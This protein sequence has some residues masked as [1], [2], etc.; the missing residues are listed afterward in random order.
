MTASAQEYG[1]YQMRDVWNANYLNPGFFPRQQFVLSLPSVHT[2]VNAVGINRARLFTFNEAEQTNYLNLDGVL[3][4]INRDLRLRNQTQVDAL[5]FGFRAGKAFVSLSTQ[6]MADW[7]M[8]LPETL[9]RTLWEGTEPYLGDPIDLGPDLDGILYQKVS[10]GMGYMVTPRLSVGM[11]VNRL[12]GLASF[13]TERSGLTILQSKDIYQTTVNLDYRVNYYGAGQYKPIDLTVQGFENFEDAISEEDIEFSSAENFRDVNQQNNGW[14]FDFGGEYFYD[15]RLTFSAALLNVGGIMWKNGTQQVKVSGETFLDGVD[16]VALEDEEDYEFIPGID[17]IGTFEATSNVAYRQNLGPRAYLGANYLVKP[18]LE[19][20]GLFYNDF[21]RDRGMTAFSLSSRLMLGR[22]FSLGALYTIQSGTFNNLG[23]NA[24]LK[25]GPFQLY[26]V[27]DNLSPLINPERID[28]ANFRFGMNLTFGRKKSEEILGYSRLGLEYPK[29][30]EGIASAPKPPRSRKKKKKKDKK[31]KE[32][33]PEEAVAEAPAEAEFAPAAAEAASFYKL[34][35]DL[36]DE[37]SRGPVNPVYVDVY[38]LDTDGYTTLLRT[39]RFPKGEVDM[40]LEASSD[41]HIAKVSA[42]QYDTL[43]IRFQADPDQALPKLWYMVGLSGDQEQ[44]QAEPKTDEMNETPAPAAPLQVEE[45]AITAVEEQVEIE[46][47]PATEPYVT[48]A[49]AETPMQSE[50]EPVVEEELVVEEAPAP[51]VDE[52]EPPVYTDP[53]PA[54]PVVE[55]VE[56][57]PAPV[58]SNEP[59]TNTSQ[60]ASSNLAPP[61][62]DYILTKRTSLRAAPDS[63]SRVISRMSENTEL[64]LLEQ[65]NQWWWRVSMGGWEGYVKA[66]YLKK[67]R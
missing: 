14:S 43:T 67:K 24:A 51:A 57:A 6:T 42:Y 2:S 63:Q 50:P 28:G 64:R 46:E 23:A 32:R 48:E 16:V 59:D 26:G 60:A 61:A 56:P 13:Q 54:P 31:E 9:L 62:T 11:R 52:A 36:L 65:T 34:D 19:V 18:Y 41:W 30:G 20:G 15:D 7:Q 1:L 37:E 40:V 39:G 45:S 4:E 12:L 35:L 5:G 53:E 49:P 8:T 3:G 38:K 58:T 29:D 17:T 66:G 25:L 55:E 21:G 47:A 44:L 10:L 22:I 33:K 27:A